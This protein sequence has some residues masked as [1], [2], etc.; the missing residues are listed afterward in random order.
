M[1]FSPILSALVHF[2]TVQTDN[3]DYVGSGIKSMNDCR[4]HLDDVMTSLAADELKI[5]HDNEKY[6][7]SLLDTIENRKVL[8]S[9]LSELLANCE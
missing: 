1:K 4:K 2:F 8:Q 9:K 6:K 5:Q 7:R 3:F